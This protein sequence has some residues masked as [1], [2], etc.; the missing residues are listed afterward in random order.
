MK[1]DLHGVK[2]QDV[3]RIVDIFLWE[4]MT[5]K[6]SQVIIITGQSDTMKSIV[7]ECVKEYGME[8]KEEFLNTGSL[9]INLI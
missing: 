8:C 7:K 3:R 2:H 4:N 9:L 1:L 6:K 5:K